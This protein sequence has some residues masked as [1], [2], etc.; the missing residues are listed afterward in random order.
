MPGVGHR[1]S[2]WIFREKLANAYTIS[3]N[4]KISHLN[5]KPNFGF[6]KSIS[7]RILNFSN[8]V[9]LLKLIMPTLIRHKNCPL[10][11]KNCGNPICEENWSIVLLNT[12][13]F[14]NDPAISFNPETGKKFAHDFEKESQT[15][16]WQIW[17]I[18]RLKVSEKMFKTNFP[19]VF[20]IAKWPWVPSNSARAQ[21]L[22]TV[23]LSICKVKFSFLADLCTRRRSP[24]LKG[25]LSTELHLYLGKISQTIKGNKIYRNVWKCN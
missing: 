11:C 21:R 18:R 16:V 12:N 15:R 6:S 3:A 14:H 2:G 5:D 22:F 24:K 4:P 20:Q 17:R 1:D 7:Y 10:G 9:S 13:H 19:F 23:V 25:A 8:R